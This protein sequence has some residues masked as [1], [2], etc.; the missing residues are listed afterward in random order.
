MKGFLLDK[1]VIIN[2]N[3]RSTRCNGGESGIRTL[4]RDKPTL[5]FK[6]STFNRSVNSP[7]R[8]IILGTTTQNNY[9]VKFDHFV[10]SVCTNELIRYFL[11][12]ILYNA[13][14][15]KLEINQ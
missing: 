3:H 6:T 10:F 14:L 8:E 5:V 12:F 7:R 13:Q 2:V 15:H 1:S 11:V 4:G 9:K